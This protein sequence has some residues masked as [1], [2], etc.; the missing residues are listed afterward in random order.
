MVTEPQIRTR[1]RWHDLPDAARDELQRR[2][3]ARVVGEHSQTGGYTPG[4]ASRLELA[5]GRRAFLKAIPTEHDLIN[6]Y[7]NET[8]VAGCLPP[9]SPAPHLWW[10]GEVQ[11]WWLAVFDDIDGAHP[12]MS[13]GATQLP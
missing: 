5:D 3:A 1:M 7:R 4:I 10:A 8:A 13:P 9:E 6:T 2:C 11:G 12:D